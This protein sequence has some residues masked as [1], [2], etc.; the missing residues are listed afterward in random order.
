[1]TTEPAAPA[2]VNLLGL[3][4]ADLGA[5][6]AADAIAARPAG[7]PFG[8]V[9]TPNADH[10]VRLARDPTLRPVYEGAMTRLLDSRVVARSARAMGLPVPRVAPGSDV[11]AALLQRHRHPDEPVTIVG[12]ESRLLPALTRRCK[13]TR[14]AHHNPSMGFE[15]DPAAFGRAVEFVLAHPAR[16]TFLAVGSPRQE[17]LAAAIAATGQAT[18]T[19]LCIGAGLEF[20]A[21]AKTRAPVWMRRFGLEWLMRLAC[22]PRRLSRRYLLDCPAVFRLLWSARGGVIS[23]PQVPCATVLSRPA[24]P[25]S[26]R[27]VSGPRAGTG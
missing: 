1:M 17:R 23:W 18:G 24:A 16:F 10:F 11:A 9:V 20:L 12:L 15:R 6:A 27:R 22:E 8:Y 4:F 21:G 5:E 26:H 2:V 19:G 3:D 13:L 7:A 14:L 25:P